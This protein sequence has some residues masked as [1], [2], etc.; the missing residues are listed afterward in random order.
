[1]HCFCPYNQTRQEIIAF[2]NKSI[3]R[4]IDVS[5][6]EYYAFALVIQEHFL[7]LLKQNLCLQ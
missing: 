4:N 5:E 2:P 7:A 6:S 1:M 3:L